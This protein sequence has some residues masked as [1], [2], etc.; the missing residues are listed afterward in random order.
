[1]KK[2]QKYQTKVH[3]E[4]VQFINQ[5][6]IEMVTLK[7]NFEHQQQETIGLNDKISMLEDEAEKRAN[8]LNEYVLSGKQSMNKVLEDAIQEQKK[9]E[10][11]IKALK[12]S[13]QLISSLTKKCNTQ[14]QIIEEIED[15]QDKTSKAFNQEQSIVQTICNMFSSDKEGLLDFLQT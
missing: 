8:K 3:F 13:E 4:Q 15:K 7:D 5:L 9:N 12:E 6:Q 10:L 11:L 1:M 2:S 14:S